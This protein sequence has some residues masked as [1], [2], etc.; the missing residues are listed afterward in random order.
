MEIAFFTDSYLPTRDG[1]ATVTSALARELTFQGHP[2]TVFTPSPTPGPGRDEAGPDGVTVVRTRSLRVPLYGQYRWGLTPLAPLLD[3]N[4]RRFD[5]VHIHTPGMMGSAGFLAARHFRR[6]LVGTFHTNVWEMRESFPHTVPLRLFFRLARWYALGAYYRCEVTTVP[7]E[8]TRDWIVAHSRKRFRRPVEVVPNGIEVERFHPGISVPDWR[9]R[10]ALPEA[11][12]VT[13]LGR[14]TVDKGVHRFLDALAGLGP[15]REFAAIVAGDGPE[16]ER[17]R[18][19]LRTDPR[20]A[21]RVRYVGPVVEAEK[22][23]LLAQ[24]DLFVLPSVSD[25]SS[26][27]LLEAMACGAA[28]LVSDQGGARELVE[29]GVTGRC[30]PV[31][32]PG[33]LAEAIGEL[34]EQ[35]GEREA[36]RR[37]ALGYVRREAS[38]ERTA[39]RFMALY[40]LLAAERRAGG[41]RFGG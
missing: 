21:G 25:T 17:V 40:E 29:E 11:P 15:R 31:L 9:E 2:V 5:V 6:P 28:C 1:V 20:L 35:P 34:L 19:R 16:Q 32:E 36:M 30:V 23:S 39:T 12:L 38:I 27:A 10:C 33:A 41:A 7:T 22:A 18:E 26:I 37:A 14:L 8:P 24:T 4:F 3:R 13:F